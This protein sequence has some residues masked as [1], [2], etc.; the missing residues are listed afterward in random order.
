MTYSCGV[1]N[2]S[3]PFCIFQLR[4][5]SFVRVLGW[6]LRKRAGGTMVPAIAYHELAFPKCFWVSESINLNLDWSLKKRAAERNKALRINKRT[7]GQMK[8]REGKRPLGKAWKI[9]GKKVRKGE[10]RCPWEGKVGSRGWL[11]D[12]QFREDRPAYGCS[13]P[14]LPRWDHTP[15]SILNVTC[16]Q[17]S[18]GEESGRESS[19]Q[20]MKKKSGFGEYKDIW[21]SPKSNVVWAF[22]MQSGSTA[23]RREKVSQP[24][25]GTSTCTTSNFG[26]MSTSEAVSSY[27][28]SLFSLYWETKQF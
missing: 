18:E 16:W 13:Q 4:N 11:W 2:V 9:G 27:V 14:S 3:T 19:L 28:N 5:F 6:N 26:W 20:I 8:P 10:Q 7:K 24:N 1:W 23:G 22:G 12:E 21:T 17:N 25:T 15:R